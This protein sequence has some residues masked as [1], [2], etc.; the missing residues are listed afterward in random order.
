MKALS[1]ILWGASIF[2]LPYT[3]YNTILMLLNILVW[4]VSVYTYYKLI[5]NKDY[6]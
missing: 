3:A 5:N 1:L 4:A 2:A 6:E